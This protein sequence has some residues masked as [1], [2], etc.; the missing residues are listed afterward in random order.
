MCK[1]SIDGETFNTIKDAAD[2]LELPSW[3]LTEILLDK[4]EVNVNGF[5]V[6][7]LGKDRIF[8][9]LICIET[10]EVFNTMKDLA[11]YLGIQP[12]ELSKAFAEKD[13]YIKDGKRYY[14]LSEKSEI[15]KSRPK[16]LK[17]KKCPEVILDDFE[18]KQDTDKFLNVN[19]ETEEPMSEQLNELIEVAKKETAAEVIQN[20]VIKFINNKDYETADTLLKVLAKYGD[21]LNIA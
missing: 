10:Q 1:V 17:G 18:D 13:C 11:E 9:K 16:G 6:K 19:I 15:R 7:K 2:F 5:N 14:R 12:V 3:K 21:K 8:T 20:L 4:K